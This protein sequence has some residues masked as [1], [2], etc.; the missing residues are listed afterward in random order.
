MARISKEDVN[1]FTNDLRREHRANRI[2]DDYNSWVESDQARA[3]AAKLPKDTIIA[4]G[5]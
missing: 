4:E 5:E 3:L 1:I 2:T